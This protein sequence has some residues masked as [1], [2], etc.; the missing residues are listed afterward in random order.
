MR[1]AMRNLQWYLLGLHDSKATSEECK[2]LLSMILD[3][4]ADEYIKQ[5]A[6]IMQEHEVDDYQFYPDT[7][8]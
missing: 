4:I 8:L 1:S 3:R 2:E 6:E 5:E 7:D